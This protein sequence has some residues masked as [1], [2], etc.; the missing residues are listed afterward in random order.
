MKFACISESQ[1]TL[2]MPVGG[3]EIFIGSKSHLGH[4]HKPVIHLKAVG[5]E[6]SDVGTKANGQA[7]QD[8]EKNSGCCELAAIVPSEVTITFTCHEDVPGESVIGPDAYS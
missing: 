1:F 3:T 7:G 6:P 2:V 4:Q 8:Q 5:H